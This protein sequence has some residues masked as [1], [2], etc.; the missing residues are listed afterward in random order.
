MGHEV[1]T[2][3]SIDETVWF[4]HKNHIQ[5]A[6][7]IEVRIRLENSTPMRTQKTRYYFRENYGQR[8][9][10]KKYESYC[11]TSKEELIANLKEI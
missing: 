10:I 1:K 11:F 7:V 3:Y 2:K 6:K 9:I 5:S 4:F 8:K